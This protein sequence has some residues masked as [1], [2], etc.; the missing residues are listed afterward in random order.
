MAG[1]FVNR[2]RRSFAKVSDQVYG[3]RCQL[4]ANAE[5]TKDSV[6]HI[7]RVDGANYLPEFIECDAQFI[8]NQLVTSSDSVQFG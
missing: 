5:A 2:A 3:K 8:C 4:F 6:Q 1:S 7:V